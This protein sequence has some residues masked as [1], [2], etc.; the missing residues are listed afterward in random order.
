M[1]SITLTVGL[2]GCGKSTW[3]V[4]Q[5]AKAKSKTININ[6]DDIRA[7]LTG[8]DLDSYKFKKDNEQYVTDVQVNMA[9]DAV[10]RNWNIIVSDTN[11]NP[12][13]FEM[14][15]TFAKEHKYT[16]KVQDFFAEF[17]KQSTK[18][19]PHEYFHMMDYV[20]RCKTWDLLRRK[21]VGS[22]VIDMM[23]QKYFYNTIEFPKYI[24]GLQEAIIVDIDGTLAHMWNRSPFDET[25]VLDDRP[26]PEVI[27]S[28][29]AEKNYLG[30]TVIIM[31][32]RHESCRENTIAWLE[33]HNI[34]YDFL[35]MRGA[36]DNRGDDIV[37]YELY[38]QHVYGKFET[39]KVFDDRTRVVNMWR[40]LL[41][42]K[43]LQVEYGD[44]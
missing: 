41:G 37:K 7:T 3:T 26:S 35:F 29:L 23:V 15:K 1:P 24:K 36:E 8:G 6:R 13:I 44:F 9:L 25:K 34:P 21:S 11:L 42:L 19:V 2:P 32:G 20:H 22:E 28:V 39:V 18:E 14:W 17:V 38:M 5:I 40:R 27:L 16:F 30:R 4:A 12:T 33:K 43:V 31:S 10:T